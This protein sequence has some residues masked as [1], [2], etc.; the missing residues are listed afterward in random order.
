[1]KFTTLVYV[2]YAN[3]VDEHVQCTI[4]ADSLQQV[5]MLAVKEIGDIASRY[6][7]HVIHMGEI[8]IFPEEESTKHEHI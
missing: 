7:T 8:S 4:H 5:R 6:N 2:Q 3:G 1:M